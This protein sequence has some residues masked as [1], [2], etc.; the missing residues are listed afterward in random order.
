VAL[1]GD[2]GRAAALARSLPA[3]V[4]AAIERIP[5]LAFQG[6]STSAGSPARPA[7]SGWPAG[8]LPSIKADGASR[9]EVDEDEAVNLILEPGQMSL[10]HVKIFHGSHQ[11]RS[12]DRRIGFAIRYLP[13]QV[14]PGAGS[15][16]ASLVRGEDR[17]GH[18]ELEPSPE[19]DLAPDA[20]AFHKWVRERRMAIL[21]R[22][23]A[24]DSRAPHAADAM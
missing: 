22:G 7:P 23:A 20:I 10:H 15:D 2:R 11:N 6:P 13:P 1:A 5:H 12:A 19:A 4:V 3:L 8:E 16:S 9:V 17:H 21:M 24:A 18:F 14:R